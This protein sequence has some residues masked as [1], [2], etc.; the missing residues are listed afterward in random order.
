MKPFF[1]I[2]ILAFMFICKDSVAS[3][4]SRDSLQTQ[5][6]SVNI[7]PLRYS[8]ANFLTYADSTGI[9]VKIIRQMTIDELENLLRAIEV[10]L[11]YNRIFRK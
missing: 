3:Y 11:E 5:L 4:R 2:T 1:I 10:W 8:T 9:Y 6:T 7:M